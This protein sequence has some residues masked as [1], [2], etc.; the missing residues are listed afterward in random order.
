MM[1]QKPT[2]SAS[3]TEGEDT[4]GTSEREHDVGNH[5]DAQ[6]DAVTR[7]DVGDVS[8]GGDVGDGGE[9]VRLRKTESYNWLVDRKTHEQALADLKKSQAVENYNVRP[10]TPGILQDYTP[11]EELHLKTHSQAGF[12][13]KKGRK[14]PMI[15]PSI[16][17]VPRAMAMH[18]YED[19][20]HDE[21][22]RE[23]RHRNAIMKVAEAGRV[24]GKPRLRTDSS[25]RNIER[26]HQHSEHRSVG[27][28]PVQTVNA[29]AET[30]KVRPIP[31]KL[32][33]IS[34]QIQEQKGYNELVLSHDKGAIGRPEEDKLVDPGL[35]KL[36]GFL[37]RGIVHAYDHKLNCEA[38]AKAGQ[39]NGRVPEE[40][41]TDR[42]Q[43]AFDADAFPGVC[44]DAWVVERLGLEKTL[45]VHE[46]TLENEHG[47][48]KFLR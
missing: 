32:E 46:V 40:D 31:P 16:G 41:R 48:G 1:L 38:S 25:S 6:G 23:Y 27:S 15:T 19:E 9:D 24:E 2:K 30:E 12:G 18:G 14:V 13:V 7:H 33:A 29:G 11:H 37:I 35:V 22:L 4:R 34:R 3:A 42:R 39:K 5:G 20:S 43:R 8:D 26:V 44:V 17:Q 10:K 45:D 28:V 47:K 21:P 36:M